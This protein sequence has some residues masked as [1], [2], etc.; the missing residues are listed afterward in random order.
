MVVD[1]V[2]KGLQEWF[3]AAGMCWPAFPAAAA[4]GAA[5]RA[6]LA[7]CARIRV[8]RWGSGS[9]LQP[10][11]SRAMFMSVPTGK[12]LRGPLSP[13]RPPAK[14]HTLHCVP[15]IPHLAAG[16]SSIQPNRNLFLWLTSSPP[17]PHPS[18]PAATRYPTTQT[19]YIELPSPHRPPSIRP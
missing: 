12:A 15:T 2:G 4:S 6:K 18:C 7:A 9:C 5:A 14:T 17:Q 16:H 13:F 1:P 10:A 3:G 8:E 11:A 19:G